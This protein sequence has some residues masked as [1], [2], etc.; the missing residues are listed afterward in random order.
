MKRTQAN[1]AR[2]LLQL[3]LCSCVMAASPQVP[4]DAPVSDLRKASL[5]QLEQRAHAIDRELDQIAHYNL[6]SGVG[7]IGYRSDVALSAAQSLWIEIKLGTETPIDLIVLVPSIWRDTRAGFKADG[8]PLKFRI[9]AGTENH[10]EG[11]VLATF[12]EHSNLLPRIAP[13]LIPC[14][15]TAS[16]VRI[17]ADLLS[18]RQ[19]DGKFNLELSEVMVFNGATNVAIHQPITTSSS[20][21]K[22]KGARKKAYL[23][24]GFTPFLMDAGRGE[25]T[26]AFLGVCSLEASP[27]ITIDLEANY[28]VSRIQ[29]HA[30]DFNDTVPQATPAGY[31]L[32]SHLRIEGAQQADFS[33]AVTL[34]EYQKKSVYDVGPILTQRFPAKE[35]RY[36]RITALQPYV[37][38]E[39][40]EDVGKAR[41]GFAE[42]EIFANDTNVAYQK[43]ATSKQLD[44]TGRS[45]AALTDGKNLYGKILPIRK[46]MEELSHRND[47]EY[48]RPFVEEALNQRYA[49]QKKMLQ[50]FIWSTALLIVGI[51]FII[52]IER[53][54]RIRQITRIKERFAADLH[55]ELGA[56]LHTIGLLSDLSKEMIHSP[57]KLSNLLDR[58][59]SFTQRSGTAARYCTNMLE[60]EGICE[61][62][63]DEMTRSSKRLLADLDYDI[64]FTGE[65]RLHALKP[66]VRIDIFLFFKECL[67][68]ILRH[69]GATRVS[70]RL[71]ARPDRIHLTI[72]DNGHGIQSGTNTVPPSSKRRARLL[73]ARVSAEHPQQGG[74]RI[75]LTVKPKKFRI[76]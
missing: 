13:V 7:S 28:P 35:C 9:V 3:L 11:T 12:D 32:P 43:V 71:D 33:D 54:R 24:D 50:I 70:I 76:L 72:T 64:K 39:D 51:G 17:E 1:V 44:S 6:R 45:L 38:E 14:S 53:T 55:D 74:T 36:V 57:E 34:T 37:F 59:R 60:A 29:L 67:I 75:R 19:F 73:R 56:N 10:P 4:R 47:L 41:M 31:G 20:A 16:W 21:V 30:V 22:V 61:D 5:A 65:A 27:S 23:V 49:H 68:N 25:S 26:V 40:N 15:I 52:L 63:V 62:L 48:E 69:S 58:I 2:L 46:W 66:R 8:F 42:I 18:P